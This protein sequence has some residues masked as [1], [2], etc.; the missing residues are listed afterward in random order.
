M[1]KNTF[2]EPKTNCDI[3]DIDEY[4]DQKALYFGSSEEYTKLSSVFDL[5]G[6]KSKNEPAS[7][8]VDRQSQDPSDSK[9][10]GIALQSAPSLTSIVPRPTLPQHSVLVSV[11][12]TTL[13]WVGDAD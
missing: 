1:L 8:A 10:S 9:Y 4:R 3:Y 7:P 11:G 2:R 12:V 6:A 13:L 5:L